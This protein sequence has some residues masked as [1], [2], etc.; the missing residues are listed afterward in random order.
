[1]LYVEDLLAAYDAAIENID[2]AAGEVFNIGGGPGNTISIWTEFGPVLETMLGREVPITRGDWRPG[3]QKVFIADI[4]KSARML[5]W[6][7]KVDL[8]AGMR[9]LYTWIADNQALFR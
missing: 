9:K 6:T 5:A 2:S 4:R 7:P 1:M 8:S 3:D